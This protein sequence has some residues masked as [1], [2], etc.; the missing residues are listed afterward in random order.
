MNIALL[1]YSVAPVVGGVEAVIQAHTRLL[2]EAGNQVTLIAGAGEQAAL[3]D[4]A[5]FV[6]IPLMDTRDKA[7]EEMS[8][9]L[10]AGKVPENFQALSARLEASLE[11]ALEGQ[12]TVIVHNIFTKHFNLP[13]TAAFVKLLERGKISHCIAWCHDFSWTSPH[14]RQSVHPGYPWDLLRTYWPG[15]RYVTVS[16]QRRMELAGLFSCPP[17]QISVVYNGVDPAGLYGFSPEGL[18]LVNRLGMLDADLV[19][20]M[21]VR[22]TQAKNIELAF[23]VVASLKNRSIRSKLV[24]TG[25]PDPHDLGDMAYYQNLL[26]KRQRVGVESEA[27][28]VYESGP[29]VGDAYV[30]GL[31][32]VNELYRASDVLFMPSHREGFGMP[33]LEAGLIGMPIFTTEIPAAQEIGKG[34]VIYFSAKDLPDRV[35][36]LILEWFEHSP[37]QRL[38]QRVRQQFTWPAIFRQ[39]LEPLLA[40]GEPA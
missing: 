2:L 4:G 22:I 33:I 6:R 40:G 14:S 27:R 8:Q 5:D 35:A 23:Q 11:Q 3:P 24:V 32:M 26:D 29:Q 21:P 39:A 7:V 25:P 19:L 38:R 34:E 15:I 37:S 28:F 16:E 9:Q 17:S 31:S 12:D 13:L 20:L 30:I 1:H 18:A 10:E 36:G